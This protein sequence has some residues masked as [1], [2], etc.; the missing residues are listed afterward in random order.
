MWNIANKLTVLRMIMVPIYVLVFTL[1]PEPWNRYLAF[2]LF[3]A[4]SYTDHLDG[5]LAR[6]RNL[7]T[8]FGKFMDPLA[9]KLLVISALICFVENGQLA[10]WIL[11]II[12]AREFIISGF[13]LVAASSGIVIAAGIWGKLKTVAQMIMVLLMILNFDWGWYQVLIQ[14]FVVL[15]VLLTII[16]LVDYIWNNRKVLTEKKA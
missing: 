1:V 8:N 16:S 7:I 15:S 14:I 3:A 5:K 2:I 4:A 11:I 12:V 6:E 13:R 9:D 10:G